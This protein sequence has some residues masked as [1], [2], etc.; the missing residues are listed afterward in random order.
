M[1]PTYTNDIMSDAENAAREGNILRTYD[2]LSKLTLADFCTLSMEVPSEYS[3][4]KKQFPTMPSDDVQKRW[5]GDF[6]QS[7]MNRTCN[8]ARLIQVLSYKAT[9]NGLEGK[10]IL[11]YG[12]GWGR[13]LRIMNYF[14]NVTNVYGIDVMQ[15]SLDECHKSNIPNQVALC[16]RRPVVLPFDD[17]LFDL[18]F[19]F[20][21]FSHIPEGVAYAVLNA[22]RERISKSGVLIL[23]IRSY[24]FWDLRVGV[25]PVE[26]IKKMRTEHN[27]NGYAF[28]A[29]DNGDDINKDYG[30]VTMSLEFLSSMA[31]KTGWEVSDIERDLSEPYQIAVSLKPV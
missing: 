21:V 16:E 11:D 15:S 6:G 30:D 7:L 5:V 23:T 1:L 14:A 9:G 19:A 10:K 2:M 12:C 18:V 25:W 8:F 31:D 29:F 28:H 4:L 26:L 22:I 13:L 24:E 20:S 27:K 17:L 3:Y